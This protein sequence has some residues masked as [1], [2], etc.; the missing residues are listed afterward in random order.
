MAELVD[1]RN[2]IGDCLYACRPIQRYIGDRHDVAILVSENLGGQVLHRH[3][4]QY[5]IPVL[6]AYQPGAYERETKLDVSRAFS[7]GKHIAAAY[8][9]Q[10]GVPW[11]GDRS[12]PDLWAADIAP[13]PRP[14]VIAVSPFSFSD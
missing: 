8:S 6:T 5:A 3:F 4:S 12:I 13:R 9:D 11:D 14:D 10:L 2:L 7:S 1:N